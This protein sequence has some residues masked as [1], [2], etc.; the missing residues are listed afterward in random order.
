MQPTRRRS[1][2]ALLLVTLLCAAAFLPAGCN[3]N[4]PKL[5]RLYSRAASHLEAER[6]PVIVIP[7]ILGSRLVDSDSGQ[8]VW[9]AFGGGSINPST[10]EGMRL[11]AL[12]MSEGTPARDIRDMVIPDGALDRLNLNLWFINFRLSAYYNILKALGIGGYRDEDI[13]LFSDVQ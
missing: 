10:P 12:P 3:R 8:V 9:G 1:R 13:G 4:S 5:G 7:G 6:N 2:H 11:A